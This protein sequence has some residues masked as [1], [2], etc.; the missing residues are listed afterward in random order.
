MKQVEVFILVTGGEVGGAQTSVLTLATEL[1]RQ[2]VKV[3]IGHGSR[4]EFLPKEAL[5]RKIPTFVFPS[6]ARTNNP[7]RNLK[8]FWAFKRFLRQH[9]NI[10]VVHCNSSN[11]L[12]A[13]MAAKKVSPARKTV[14]TMRGLSYLDPVYKFGFASS[15]KKSF[16]EIIFRFFMPFVDE[17]V[18]VSKSNLELCPAIGIQKSSLIYNSLA[19]IDFTSREEARSFLQTQGVDVRP[20][21]FIL[22][23]IGRLESPKH[24]E[25]IILA[26]P[27]II[28]KH[29]DT[30]FVLIGGGPHKY[31]YES[32]LVKHDLLGRVFLLG[33]VP[34]A[35]RYLKGLDVFVLPSGYEGL[36]LSLIEAR[37]AGVPIIATDVG[38]NKEIVE[39]SFGVY[40]FS[41]TNKNKADFLDLFERLRNL[42]KESAPLPE[43]FTV[44]YMTREYGKIYQI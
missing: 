3:G 20:D 14:F 31:K 26:M 18:F 28:Q 4:G 19:P 29:L 36:S 37:Q 12:F 42:E 9:P 6:L 8:F 17:V 35:A 24:Y 32:L 16:Y 38:G 44:S 22:G 39:D 1:K 23:S 33:E 21:T 30:I 11:T 10:K 34:G 27:E 41:V 40:P 43:H 5:A 25:Q 13:A 2:G 7:L 15:V